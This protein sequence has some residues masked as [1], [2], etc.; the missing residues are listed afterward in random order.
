MI[1]APTPAARRAAVELAAAL[2]SH[3]AIEVVPDPPQ[4]PLFHLL[5]HGDGERLVEAALD[6]AEERRVWLFERLGS[7]PSPTL[8]RLE[9]TPGPATLDWSAADVRALFDE[10]L[11]RAESRPA[12]TS[13]DG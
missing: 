11:E 4:T 12:R 10:L 6:I 2:A 9:L 1:P 7:T 8:H 5:L 13:S 3:P